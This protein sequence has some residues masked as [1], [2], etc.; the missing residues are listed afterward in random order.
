MSLL[1]YVSIV[2][3]IIT[4]VLMVILHRVQRQ[5]VFLNR[6]RL[7][8]A[9]R[10]NASTTLASVVLAGTIIMKRGWPLGTEVTMSVL[11]VMLL[12]WIGAL[13]SSLL[14]IP[15]VKFVRR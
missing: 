12:I 5:D 1:L 3:F 10:L 6:R 14:G 2:I 11:V 8:L 7:V 9:L 4:L 15:I 13:V